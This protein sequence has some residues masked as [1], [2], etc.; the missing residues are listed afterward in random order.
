MGCSHGD[1]QVSVGGVARTVKTGTT[2]S[3]HAIRLHSYEHPGSLG[4]LLPEEGN[5][6]TY[7]A[8]EFLD[9]YS[10]CD[11]MK[12]AQENESH[13]GH[14][15]NNMQESVLK[16][17]AMSKGISKE[18]FEDV[19]VKHLQSGSCKRFLEKCGQISNAH[20][21]HHKHCPGYGCTG[22]AMVNIP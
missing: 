19:W 18:Y 8:G 15:K 12:R 21:V 1:F 9:W 6:G 20:G 13:T 17:V 22:V 2:K 10:Y 16:A 14:Y 4:D 11:F 7:E 3:K 5:A